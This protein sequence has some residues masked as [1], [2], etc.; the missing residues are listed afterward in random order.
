MLPLAF[1]FYL[2]HQYEQQQSRH[3]CV[4]LT[5]PGQGVEVC[6]SVPR[7]LQVRRP[8]LRGHGAAAQVQPAHR[9]CQSQFADAQQS[10]GGQQVHVAFSEEPQDPPHQEIHHQS[11]EDNL[12]DRKQ[13]FEAG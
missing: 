11:Q 4:H 13:Q 1:P 3:D 7:V 8:L 9:Y 12:E 10:P 5:L 6:E 2:E